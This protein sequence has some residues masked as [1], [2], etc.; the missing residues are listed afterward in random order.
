LSDQQLFTSYTIDKLQP[1]LN[2]FDSAEAF[3]KEYN[4]DNNELDKF[5]LYASQTIKEINSQELLTSKSAIKSMIKA[6]AA[7]FKWGDNAYYEAINTD[8][9][10]LAKAVEAVR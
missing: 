6:S 2:K 3:I 8:D 4:V 10:T 9:N 7:R 5:I 1:E